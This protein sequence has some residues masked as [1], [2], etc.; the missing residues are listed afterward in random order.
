MEQNGTDSC[1]ILGSKSNPTLNKYKISFGPIWETEETRSALLN[2]LN[3]MSIPHYKLF[4]DE[5]KKYEKEGRGEKQR[6]KRAKSI[7]TRIFFNTE[8]I[9]KFNLSDTIINYYKN[10]QNEKDNSIFTPDFFRTVV[11][12]ICIPIENNYFKQFIKSKLFKNFIQTQTDDI[13]TY[14]Q[15]EIVEYDV[16]EEEEEQNKSKLDIIPF[17][18]DIEVKDVDI[19]DFPSGSASFPSLTDIH[20]S[21][22]KLSSN[23]LN[24]WIDSPIK[25]K[26][27]AVLVNN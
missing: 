19:K 10:R 25:G 15:A 4:M 16:E 7:I 21:Y 13:F 18:Q 1:V 23:A 24:T 12:K 11:N 20:F 26:E 22:L 6:A 27:I 3:W 8:F 2:Y 17:N 14:I 5:I 9:K